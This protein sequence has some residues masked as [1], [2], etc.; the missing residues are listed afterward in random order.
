M[1]DKKSTTKKIAYTGVISALGLAILQIGF[2]TG[3]AE[4]FWYYVTT[5]CI[6]S[7]ISVGGRRYGFYCYL[8]I[9]SLSLLIIPGQIFYI[10]PFLCFMGLHPIALSW[11]GNRKWMFVLIEIWYIAALL[12]VYKMTELTILNIPLTPVQEIIMVVIAGALTFWP[13]NYAIGRCQIT[14]DGLMKK[15]AK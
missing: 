9:V 5:L 12:F 8:V 14:F 11:I 15:L 2:F 7:A 6:I 13:Y 10:L 1:R 4:Y 3:V